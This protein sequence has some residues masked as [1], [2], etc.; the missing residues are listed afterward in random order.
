MTTSSTT[1]SETMPV[2]GGDVYYEVRGS[3]PVLLLMPGGAPSHQ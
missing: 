1:R 2:P 3:G